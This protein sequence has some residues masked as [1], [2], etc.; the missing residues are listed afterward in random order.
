MNGEN[1][2]AIFWKGNVNSLQIQRDN[3]DDTSVC[4]SLSLSLSLFLSLSFSL[5]IFL[6]LTERTS[7]TIRGDASALPVMVAYEMVKSSKEEIIYEIY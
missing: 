5:C 3:G 6:P 2:S 7:R 4:L 1:I